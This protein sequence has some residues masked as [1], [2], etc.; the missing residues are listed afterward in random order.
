MTYPFFNLMVLPAH[1]L[2][3]LSG[4]IIVFKNSVHLHLHSGWD[5]SHTIVLLT[6]Q[7]WHINAYYSNK[8]TSSL[9]N[10]WLQQDT[11]CSKVVPL[12]GSVEICMWTDLAWTT[13]TSES[14]LHRGLNVWALLPHRWRIT[15]AKERQWRNKQSINFKTKHSTWMLN[16][17][18][19]GTEKKEKMWAEIPD[20]QLLG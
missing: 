15:A 3:E 2:T 19:S 14:V 7:Y 18:G 1:I 9:K 10:S 11:F 8:Y 12:C 5:I 20:Y 16:L 6:F 17:K 13:S 4:F